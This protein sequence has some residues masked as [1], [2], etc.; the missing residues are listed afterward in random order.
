MPVAVVRVRE[1]RMAV[2]QGLVPVR[3]A[4]PRAGGNRRHVHMVMVRVAGAVH[5]FVR[6][7]HRLVRMAVLV[8]LGQVQ[9][10]PG[11]SSRPRTAAR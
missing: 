1:V 4:V 10:T 7:L 9:A 11:P 8:P 5:V 6:V 3:M 2:H